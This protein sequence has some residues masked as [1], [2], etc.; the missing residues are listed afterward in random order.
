MSRRTGTQLC[1]RFCFWIK[2]HTVCGQSGSCASILDQTILM[3]VKLM[4]IHF[5][6]WFCF[7]FYF[8]R[9]CPLISCLFNIGVIWFSQPK[10]LNAYIIV[11]DVVAD[12]VFSLKECLENWKDFF[13]KFS[14]IC[15]LLFVI[16]FISFHVIGFGWLFG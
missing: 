11:V 12:D 10:V 15:Y 7:Y 5:N 1:I 2:N 13:F 3:E 8:R 14:W 6:F 4:S 9:C 16:L